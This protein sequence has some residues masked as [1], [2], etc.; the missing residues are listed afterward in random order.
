[1]GLWRKPSDVSGN[2]S[3]PSIAQHRHYKPMKGFLNF[4]PCHHQPQ[5]VFIDCLL[6]AGH[7]ARDGRGSAEEK[8]PQDFEKGHICTL[9]G[10]YLPLK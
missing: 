6:E 2:P 8:F 7:F 10:S 5:Q 1:M 3:H 9:E 4:T